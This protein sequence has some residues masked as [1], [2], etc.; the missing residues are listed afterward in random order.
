MHKVVD[1]FRVDSGY[2][3]A[4]AFLN[5]NVIIIIIIVVNVHKVREI[6]WKVV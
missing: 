5:L 3:N 1:V 4:V 6:F 2:E